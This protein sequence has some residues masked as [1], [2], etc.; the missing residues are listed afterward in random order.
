ML[1]FHHS[2][3]STRGD[4]QCCYVNSVIAFQGSAEC[5]CPKN[6]GET[7]REAWQEFPW[8][9]QEHRLMSHLLQD[10][11]DSTVT[12]ESRRA[13]RGLPLPS[14]CPRGLAPV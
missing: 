1:S 6:T 5:I 9:E 3:I 12:G 10:R 2:P 4:L 13:Q 14:P 11:G 7:K 8:C